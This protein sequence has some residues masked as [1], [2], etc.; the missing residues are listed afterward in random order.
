M[1]QIWAGR[2]LVPP[3]LQGKRARA[4]LL[5]AQAAALA[6]NNLKAWR[7][8]TAVL[9]CLDGRSVVQIAEQLGVH[10]SAVSKWLGAYLSR[11]FDALT[12]GTSPGNRPR[13][14]A[15]Q[16]QLLGELVEQGPQ[17]C[18]FAS[19]IWTARL[20]AQLI[21]Q[22]FGVRYS[23]KYVPELLH[24]MG[25]SVQRPRKRLSR[26]DQQA[27]QWWLRVKLPEIK[28]TRQPREG[29]CSSRTKPASSSTQHC[30]AP[31]LE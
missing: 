30:T 26:A 4:K 2:R 13:L 23:W 16:L 31:G 1:A 11:G 12:P 19:G 10:N 9:L 18:G 7:R 15:Q 27:Q 25:F 17:S 14:D 6:D 29:S 3:H 20:V 22:Q 24:R 8:P 5:K 28:K 21:E